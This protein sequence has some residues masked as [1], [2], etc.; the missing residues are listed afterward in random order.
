[1]IIFGGA[2]GAG[3][4][5]ARAE[6]NFLMD[7]EAARLVLRSPVPKIVVPLEAGRAF[8]ISAAP[9][10]RLEPR[11]RPERLAR[12]LLEEQL[13]PLRRGAAGGV[14]TP[15]DVLAVL[16]ASRP[17]LFAM[18]THRVS[19][20]TT[21]GPERGRF[22]IGPRSLAP[23][24]AAIVHD[25]DVPRAAAAFLRTIAPAGGG[26]SP[27]RAPAPRQGRPATGKLLT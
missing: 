12:A 1:M 11:G 6:F 22:L 21:A 23:G 3:N 8:R 15:F 26:R 25:V 5:S 19:V 2:V 24:A 13:R 10:R 20:D 27:R 17:D 7:P 16:V 9:I 18:R 14:V 4:A